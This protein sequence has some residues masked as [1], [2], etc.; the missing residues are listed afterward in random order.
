MKITFNFVK[1]ILTFHIISPNLLAQDVTQNNSFAHSKVVIVSAEQQWTNTNID[2]ISG[3]DM[4]IIIDGMASDGS[5]PNTQNIGWTG[6]EG[7]GKIISLSNFPAANISAYS[8][9]GKIGESGIPFYVGKAISYKAN[10]S[11]RLFLGYN[12]DNF[13]NNYGYFVSFIITNSTLTYIETGENE[14]INKFFLGQNYPNPFN[15][16]TTIRFNLPF[17]GKIILSIYNIYGSEV[18][19]IINEERA[20]GS[21]EVELNLINLS[22][23]IYFYRL[24]TEQFVETRKMILLK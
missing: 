7:W 22:S 23:G 6:P 12:D 15:P 18:K 4:T 5:G 16:I 24:Q 19:K 3:E 10:K 2:I 1:F 14:L 17:S 9:I 8:V 11:G 20:T 13:S 21:Y